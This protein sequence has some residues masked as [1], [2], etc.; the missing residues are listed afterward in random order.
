[1]QTNFA[2]PECVVT[3]FPYE[4]GQY[5]LQGG[6]AQILSCTTH[7]NI[8]ETSGGTFQLILAPGGPQGPNRGL[9]WTQILTPM[10]LV[11][12]GMKRA[13]HTQITMIGVI[14]DPAEMQEWRTGSPVRR[15]LFIRGMDFQYFFTLFNYYQLA[16]LGTIASAL[17]DYGIPALVS[18]ALLGPG[19]PAQISSAWYNLMMAGPDGVMGKTAFSYQ[20]PGLLGPQN[21]SVNS[22]VSFF[23]LMSTRFDEYPLT[24]EIPI[25]DF[26]MSSS[27]SWITKFMTLLPFP[28]YEF[29]VITA[30][31]LFYQNGSVNTGNLAAVP[32][33][34]PGFPSASPQLIARVNP[35]PWTN[36]VSSASVFSFDKSLWDGLPV[37]DLENNG[38]IQS[39]TQFSADEV[40]N[41]Y[42][43]N[44]LWFTQSFGGG[45]S[46]LEAFIYK[47]AVFLDT[48]SINRYGYRP[49]I[50][51]THWFADP[52]GS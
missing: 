35:L 26:F 15:A 14:T 11:I 46:N 47:Y 16:M 13:T 3:I 20:A 25:A 49:Q 4:G 6:A 44:P 40:R 22:Q 2:Y 23:D 8:R 12:I 33:T 51:E 41:F 17:P 42:V 38:F 7:K 10:S 39:Q 31:T 45:N 32:I 9:S 52:K 43:L 27:G 50:T 28:W 48:A 37:F 18:K 19:S 30:P 34:M 1:M 21:S 36:S 29:F 5:V 24:V